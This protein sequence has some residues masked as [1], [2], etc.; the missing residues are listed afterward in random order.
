MNGEVRVSV[1][2][3]K[4]KQVSTIQEL[5]PFRS[6][7]LVLDSIVRIRRV[8]ITLLSLLPSIHSSANS[9]A[10]SLSEP[11]VAFGNM[12][13]LARLQPTVMMSRIRINSS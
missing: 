5:F 6:L 1:M 3:G 13:R 11:E 7:P 12:V 4:E 8:H 10:L 9:Y 2:L